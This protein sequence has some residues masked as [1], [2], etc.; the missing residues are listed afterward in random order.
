MGFYQLLILNEKQLSWLSAW[1][2]HETADKVSLS[3]DLVRS[4]FTNGSFTFQN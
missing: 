2:G 1:L 3:V 4:I